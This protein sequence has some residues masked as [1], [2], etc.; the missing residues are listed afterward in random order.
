MFG[1]PSPSEPRENVKED[2]RTYLTGGTKSDTWTWAELSHSPPL[3][4]V[5]LS[6]E[7]DE[8][9]RIMYPDP[10]PGKD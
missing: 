3:P 6:V 1:R 8:S 4:R 5:Y 2:T 10:T 9:T 7:K